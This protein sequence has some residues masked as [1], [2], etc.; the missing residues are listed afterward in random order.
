VLIDFRQL[1]DNEEHHYAQ[2]NAYLK[3]RGVPSIHEALKELYLEPVHSPLRMLVSGPA[4]RWLSE[5]TAPTP[6]AIDSELI[7]EVHQKMLDLL[8]GVAQVVPEDETL[9]GFTPDDIA[10]RVAQK[11]SWALALPGVLKQATSEDADPGYSAAVEFILEGWA[12]E[13]WTMWGSLFGWL[14]TH[15][16][17]GMVETLGSEEISRSW[18]DEWLFHK[19]VEQAMEELEVTESEQQRVLTTIRMLLTYRAWA[20]TGAESPRDVDAFMMLRRAL[21]YQEV[22]TYIG[23]NRYEGV[24]WFHGES[25]ERWLWWIA[26]LTAL[27]SAAE[28]DQH[29][30]V[31]RLVVTQR[32][33]EQ[34]TR[35]QEVAQYS[36]DQLLRAAKG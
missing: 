22:R 5:H 4:F 6:D 8:A 33:I 19:P 34:L 12:P 9:N 29:D 15:A 1:Q 27:D 32:L 28:D 21:S 36:V 16:L 18:F 7:D 35:S 23:V 31:P 20:P 24:L 13:D 17:G 25:F 30:L 14:F 2:L 26:C 3:G 11:V 10:E